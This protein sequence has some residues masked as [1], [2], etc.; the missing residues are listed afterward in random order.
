MQ[1]E[2]TT[3]ANKV[4]FYWIQT[5]ADLTPCMEACGA[6]G[7]SGITTS[8]VI[9]GQVVWALTLNGLNQTGVEAKINEV[10]AWD[11]MQLTVYPDADSFQ[12][13]HNI[14]ST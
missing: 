13:L 12:A 7:Y 5:H 1:G 6:I 8:T 3:K 14:T 11:G 9:D 10:V 2:A 4:D